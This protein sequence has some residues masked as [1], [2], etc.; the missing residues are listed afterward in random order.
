LGDEAKV[1]AL[2]PMK[3]HS[4]RV[5]GKN[6]RLMCGEPLFSW[7]MRSLVASKYV[8]SIVV[9][10][11]SEAI[12]REVGTR[13]GGV[14]LLERP[15][16][17]RGD[18]VAVNT[19]IAHDLSKLEG[20]H[21]LQTHSTNPLLTASTIDCAIECYFEGL[22]QH[23]SLFA[24]T[25]HQARMYWGD[26]RAVNHNPDQLLRT[27]ELTPL[28]EENSCFYLF[29]RTSFEQSGNRRIGL[30]PRMFEVDKLESV[31]IDEEQDFELAEMLMRARLATGGGGL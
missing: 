22:G 28:Y 8:D 11:D 9:D 23:D 10:T 12:S 5:P 19:L 31:D 1:T 18:S 3:E 29:S 2:V 26:G 13:F 30:R 6:S 4:H 7:I 17:I 24:V 16:S 14:Q 20:E 25:R 27:Q 21:F 15:E